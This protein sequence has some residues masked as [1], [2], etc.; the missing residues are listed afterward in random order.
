MG[1][2]IINLFWMYKRI[3]KQVFAWFYWERF[4]LCLKQFGN[5]ERRGANWRS[6]T[7]FHNRLRDFWQYDISKTIDYSGI[8]Y[9]TVV[10]YFWQ[11]R[12]QMGWPGQTI[13]SLKAHHSRSWNDTG[14][15]FSQSMGTGFNLLHNFEKK[16]LKYFR[17]QSVSRK[18]S[19]S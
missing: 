10:V 9:G 19:S 8:W 12:R 16:N 1:W 15:K 13:T 14:L 7:D 17:N 11:D 3:L 6:R 4:E 2:R 5:C 18:G